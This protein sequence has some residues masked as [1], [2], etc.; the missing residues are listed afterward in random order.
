LSRRLAAQKRAGSI[1]N[2]LDARMLDY[3]RQHLSYHLSKRA[4]WDLTR[5]GAIEF[6]PLIRVN[7]VA[8]GLVLPPTG[9]DTEYLEKLKHTNLL[10]R[11]GSPED[12]A[13]AVLFLIESPF[14]TGQVIFV[15]GGR[16]MR[17]RV[18][19]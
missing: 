14:I 15:D 11:Y 17:G 2:L 5:I 16:H 7:A 8:P 6:A 9:K 10:N 18:Y 1:V 12:V 19:E 13:R 4:L 3:D